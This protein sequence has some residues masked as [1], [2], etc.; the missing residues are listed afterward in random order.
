MSSDTDPAPPAAPTPA[1]SSDKLTSVHDLREHEEKEELTLKSLLRWRVALIAAGAVLVG[2][3]VAGVSAIAFAQGKIDAAVSKATVPL[4]AADASVVR[5]V[6][7]VEQGLQRLQQQAI[8]KEA[9]DAQRF[10]VLYGTMLSGRRDPRAAELAQPID[11]G[12]P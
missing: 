9:R 4:A 1:T 10:D 2:P 5:R 11:G 12:A 3:F 7:V 6:E 8:E